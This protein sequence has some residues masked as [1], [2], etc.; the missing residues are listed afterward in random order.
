M[1]GQ[2][3]LCGG[4]SEIAQFGQERPVRVG[5][6]VGGK[7]AHRLLPVDAMQVGANVGGP[8]QGAAIEQPDDEIHGAEFAEQSAVEGDLVEAILDFDR[9]ARRRVALDRIDLDNDRI[10]AGVV[11]K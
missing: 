11:V 6:G 4:A 5:L 7:V 1:L 8:F 2:P 10:F 3:I 9:G